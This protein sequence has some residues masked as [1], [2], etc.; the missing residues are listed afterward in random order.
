MAPWEKAGDSVD[1]ALQAP[2]PLQAATMYDAMRSSLD[3]QAD[4]EPAIAEK[5]FTAI[6]A[7]AGLA[8]DHLTAGTK[9]A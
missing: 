8:S 3:H 7:Q 9:T 1:T 5:Q 6:K 4:M 2:P